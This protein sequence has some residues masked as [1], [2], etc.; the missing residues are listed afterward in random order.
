MKS[1]GKKRKHNQWLWIV[2]WV[3]TLLGILAYV[4]YENGWF[5]RKHYQPVNEQTIK[6]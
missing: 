5:G 2:L 1:K 4:G 6:K 3:I